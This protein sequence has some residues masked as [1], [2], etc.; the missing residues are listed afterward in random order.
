M[1]DCETSGLV[2]EYVKGILQIEL[3]NLEF[4]T[5]R[6]LKSGGVD[7]S[8][9]VR[10]ADPTTDY[11]GGPPSYVAEGG[12]GCRGVNTS[13][14]RCEKVEV[15][16]VEGLFE[17]GFE[18]ERQLRTLGDLDDRK[19]RAGSV[20]RPRLD[21]KAIPD[22]RMDLIEN[23]P[24]RA[25]L[26]PPVKLSGIHIPVQS[27]EQGC[28]FRSLLDVPERSLSEGIVSFFSHIVCGIDLQ[29]LPA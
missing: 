18:V 6:Q 3:C 11:V 2:A 28:I 7:P 19:S 10:F 27:E 13:G 1:V 9:N 26:S 4:I 22:L 12:H 23:L 17:F 15:D 20:D 16:E 25:L 5:L 24:G 8:F 14:C 21:D 29:R